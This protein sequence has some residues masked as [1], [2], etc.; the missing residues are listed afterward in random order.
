MFKRIGPVLA[1]ACALAVA[2]TACSG[3]RHDAGLPSGAGG[4]EPRG[5]GSAPASFHLVPTSPVAGSGPSGASGPYRVVM[6]D[7]P[8]EVR[9]ARAKPHPEHDRDQVNLDSSKWGLQPT[10]VHSRGVSVREGDVPRKNAATGRAVTSQSRAPLNATVLGGTNIDGEIDVTGGYNG[11]YLMTISD[12]GY[13]DVLG[14]AGL[15]KRVSQ[16]N[17]YCSTGL[18]ACSGPGQGAVDDRITYDPIG[19]RWI[20][21]AMY[22]SSGTGKTPV[23]LAVSQTSDPTGAYNLY[24]FSACGNTYVGDTDQ[25]HTGF[26]NQWIVVNASCGTGYPSTTVFNKSNVYAGGAL[27]LNSTYWQFVD[28]V[29]SGGNNHDNPALTYAPSESREFFTAGTI[30][31]GN[32]AVLYSYL[33]GP[34]S[35]PTFYAGVLQVMTSFPATG[36][37]AVDAPGCTGCINTFTNGVIH[38]STVAALNTGPTAIIST[39]MYGDPANARS[40]QSVQVSLNTTTVAATSLQFAGGIPGAG[41]LGSEIAMPAVPNT[42]FNAAILVYG[43][44]RSDYYPGVRVAQWNI[45]GN[46]MV[47]VNELQQGTMLPSAYNQGRW[48]DF[49]SAISPVPGTSQM[50][51]GGPVAIPSTSDPDRS[52]YF[53]IFTP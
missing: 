51:A 39:A 49:M 7:L 19:Q 29:S 43:R 20:V 17:F 44:S 16:H 46:Y 41:V 3:A 31:S 30:V 37:V 1:S 22:L 26:N 33:T 32:A 27:N 42:A 21:T 6:S 48:M 47:Y 5:A 52:D 2:L 40:T 28:P 34:V 13:V 53:A 18:P 36:P 10:L 23:I 38:S 8:R 4:A 50:V 9:G 15:V 14:A 25:P 12:A 45:D 24:Q 11:T 35:S